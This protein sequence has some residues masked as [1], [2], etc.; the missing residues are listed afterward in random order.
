MAIEI[1][2]PDKWHTPGTQFHP[3]SRLRTGFTLVAFGGVV[4]VI[5]VLQVWANL[6]RR[7][8]RFPT[9][10]GVDKLRAARIRYAALLRRHAF[11]AGVPDPRL[12]VL[13]S[14]RLLILL[15]GTERLE[16]YRVALGASP[17]A[18]RTRAGSGATPVGEYRVGARVSETAHHLLVR[19]NYPNPD[20]AGRAHAAGVITLAQRDA[21]F[22][23]HRAGEAPPPDTPLGTVSIHGGGIRGD[24]TDGSISL[25]NEAVEELWHVAR[26]GVPVSIQP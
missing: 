9:L 2:R 15:S 1:R 13:K 25:P 23:A 18:P 24:W 6:H 17:D 21:V 3:G 19:L 4:V 22:A 20:D 7:T 16:T 10:P 26:V 8:Q 11:K 12:I 5:V 14:R